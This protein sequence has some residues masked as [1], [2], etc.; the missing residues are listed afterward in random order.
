MD[1]NF[2]DEFEQI[3]DVVPTVNNDN[4]D[5]EIVEEYGG[6]E[7]MDKTAEGVESLKK[8]IKDTI[9]K[10][11]IEKGEELPT[12]SNKLDNP[13]DVIMEVVENVANKNVANKNVES[14]KEIQKTTI[15]DKEEFDLDDLDDI[16]NDIIVEKEKE[17]E[18]DNKQP[19]IVVIDGIKITD[20]N[21]N[22]MLDCPS[23]KYKPFYDRKKEF[24]E[25]TTHGGQ[26]EYN[27]W[28]G[29]LRNATVDV[30]S[31]T[32]D[33]ERVRKRMEEVQGHRERIKQIQIECNK[34][35]FYW[36]AFM[37]LLKGFLAR[38]E[39]IKPS[40]K[41]DGLVMEHM[42]DMEF[43][44]SRLE[45]LHDSAQIAEKTLESAYE[46]LSREVSICMEMKPTLRYERGQTISTNDYR[47]DY[48]D[49]S[50]ISTPDESK[51]TRGTI[52]WGDI[53]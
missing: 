17:K 8:S 36:K 48:D 25:K 45:A 31:R 6:R 26:V 53:G 52:G 49:V 27:R 35:Y 3:F 5:D 30:H 14:K 13:K 38:I 44:F 12:D 39:Y 47:D 2:L 20:G 37:P 32:F 34:Q 41:Q 1:K 15:I 24:I 22:W 16:S 50:H 29:E 11:N 33:R 18:E 46:M 23:E 28:M 7:D 40:L 43:Y 9:E 51:T 4:S 21:I 10:E 42:S 19:P